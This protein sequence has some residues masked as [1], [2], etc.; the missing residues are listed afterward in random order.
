MF[1]FCE[2]C[3]VKYTFGIMFYGFNSFYVKWLK[4]PHQILLDRNLFLLILIFVLFVDN[5]NTVLTHFSDV[6]PIHRS[7]MR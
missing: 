7:S 4:S 5:F 2:Q 6:C 3:L 1:I